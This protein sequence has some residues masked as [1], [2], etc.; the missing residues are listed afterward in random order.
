MSSN[1]KFDNDYANRARI[2]SLYV[3]LTA[4]ERC[5]LLEKSEEYNMT[6]SEYVREKIFDDEGFENES[7]GSH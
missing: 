5:Y 3:R 1:N 7:S 2:Y 6:I 4:A